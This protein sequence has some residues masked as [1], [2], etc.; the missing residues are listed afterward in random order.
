MKKAIISLD[1]EPDLHSLD[2]KSVYEGIPK[3]LEV[4]DSHKVKATLFTT[5]DCIEKYPRIFQKLMKEGHEI[6]WHG[7]R[8]ERFDDLTLKQKEESI[9]KSILCF[10]KNLGISPKGFRAVQHSSDSSTF[11]LLKK[12]GFS[13]DYSKSPLNLLQFLF[14]PKRIRRIFPEAI[15]S[16]KFLASPGPLCF[17]FITTMFLNLLTTSK[18]PSVLPSSTNMISTFPL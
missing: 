12:Y 11:S 9:K 8:H 3:I 1:I 13:Y 5:C 7:Y 14:F 16:P 6:A 2:Y 4:L 15:F 10:K 17:P 18:V